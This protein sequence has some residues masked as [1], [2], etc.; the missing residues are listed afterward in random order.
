MDSPD[1][2]DN[3]M[4]VRPAA[5]CAEDEA[6]RGGDRAAEQAKVPLGVIYVT[7]GIVE[8]FGEDFTEVLTAL[9]R[10]ETA[11]WGEIPAEDMTDNDISLALG[12]TIFSVYETK[13][14]TIWIITEADRAKTTV[15]LPR[16]HRSG[17]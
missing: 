8:T 16:E 12:Q 1:D 5:P 10:H 4:L 7:P 14:G 15:S 6:E 17:F 13:R 2:T 11:D 9:R 3:W